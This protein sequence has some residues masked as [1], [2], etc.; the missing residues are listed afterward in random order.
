MYY[1]TKF[2]YSQTVWVQVGGGYQKS[3]KLRHCPLAMGHGSYPRN[4][5]LPNVYYQ[6]QI[7]S[8]YVKPFVHNY[9]NLPKN[10]DPLCSTFQ[11]YS[12]SLELTLTDQLPRTSY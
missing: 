11:G 8:L 2:C 6:H 4:T 5:L 9:G 10:F 12:R 1:C 3:G 7:L